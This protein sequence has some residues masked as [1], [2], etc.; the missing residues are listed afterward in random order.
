MWL[1][2]LAPICEWYGR[3]NNTAHPCLA[4]LVFVWDFPHFANVSDIYF[5]TRTSKILACSLANFHHNIVKVAVDMLCY[6]EIH[7]EQQGKCMKNWRQFTWFLNAGTCRLGSTGKRSS[8]FMQ[9]PLVWLLLPGVVFWRILTCFWDS[10]G[11]LGLR[12]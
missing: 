9:R 7:D 6:D 12:S 2:K 4:I 1:C 11:V 5:F 8:V 10:E 3:R